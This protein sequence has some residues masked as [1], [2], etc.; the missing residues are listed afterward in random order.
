MN[1]YFPYLEDELSNWIIDSFQSGY[2]RSM[3]NIREYAEL[4]LS[5]SQAQVPAQAQG[6]AQVQ[7]QEQAQAQGRS[8]NSVDFQ[9]VVSF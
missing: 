3:S 8:T 2:P 1:D 6:Q 5:L 4:F 7:G 9:W